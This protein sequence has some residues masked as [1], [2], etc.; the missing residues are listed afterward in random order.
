MEQDRPRD[1]ELESAIIKLKSKLGRSEKITEGDTPPDRGG[2]RGV[3][4][5]ADGLE[6]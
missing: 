4:T 2:G 5:V 1:R 6:F 3:F